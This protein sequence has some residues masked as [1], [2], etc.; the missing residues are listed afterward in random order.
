MPALAS[1]GGA[2]ATVI[3][4]QEHDNG[5]QGV[6]WQCTGCMGWSSGPRCHSGLQLALVGSR[7]Y[8]YSPE[9]VASICPA[10]TTRAQCPVVDCPLKGLRAYSHR[11]GRFSFARKHTKP[12]SGA[13]GGVRRTPAL[14]APHKGS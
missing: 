5:V 13:G 8:G 14:P 3:S 10:R 2:T 11:L 7:K 1:T 9:T 12:H 4:D 6:A